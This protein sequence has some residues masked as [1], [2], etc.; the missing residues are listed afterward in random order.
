MAPAKKMDEIAVEVR[1][2]VQRDLETMKG[3]LQEAFREDLKKIP[4]LEKSLEMVIGK[5][6]ELLRQREASTPGSTASGK[7]LPSNPTMTPG[8]LNGRNGGPFDTAGRQEAYDGGGFGGPSYVRILVESHIAKLAFGDE[9]YPRVITIGIRVCSSSDPRCGR[10]DLE[11]GDLERPEWAIQSGPPWTSVS[12]AWGYVRILVESHIAKMFTSVQNG[13]QSQPN[14]DCQRHCILISASNPHPLST[15]VFRPQVQNLEQSENIDGQTENRLSDTET[16]AKSFAQC[17]VSLSVISPKQLPKLRAIYNVGKRNPR[18]NDP[19]I[20]NAKNPYFL[21]LLSEN[22]LEARAALRVPSLPSNQSPVKMDMASVPSVTGPPPTSMPSVNGSVMNRQPISVGNMPPATVKVN[23][24][25]LINK[26]SGA[27]YCKFHGFWTHF[28]T[29]SLCCSCC[30]P[31]SPVA[32]FFTIF[33]S[34]DMISNN[35]NGP[36]LKPIVSSISQPLRPVGPAPANVNILNNLLAKHQVINSAALP[37]GQTP[38]GMHMSNMISN[39]M[40][41]STPAQNILPSGQPA[42]TSLPGSGPLT[43]VTQTPG[44]STFSAAT[45]NVSGNSN[46]GVSQPMNN[47]QGGVSM[48]QSV[49]TMSQGNISGAQMVQTGMGMNQNMISGLG[50]SVVSSGTGTMM[51]T[52]GMSQQVQSG[53]QPLGVNNNSA[54]SIPMSQQASTAPQA[55]KYVKVWEGNLSGQRQGQPVFITRLEGYRNATASETLAANWPATMQIVRLI[56]QDHMN[57]KQYVGKAD[58]LVFRAMNQHGFLGQLQEKKLCAVI[59]LPSQTLLLSVSDKACRLIGMLF[60][61]SLSFGSRALDLGMTRRTDGH[62]KEKTEGP[63]EEFQKELEGIREDLKKIPRLEQGMELLLE[64]MD[65]LMRQR[66]LGN[67]EPPWAAEGTTADPP[68]PREDLHREGG[69]RAELCTRRVEMPVF[70]GENPDGWSIRA[71]RYFAMNKMTEREKL[72][73]A[74]VSLEGEALAWFQ[75]EDGRSPIRSWMVLKLML[76]ERFRPMQEGSLCEKFLSL[77]QETT[78]RDY[79]RQF[80]ILAAP[81]TELSE[82]VLESTFVKGLKP[83]IRA[84][85]RLM[86]PERLGRIMEV[87][88]RVE[89]RNQSVCGPRV[90]GPQGPQIFFLE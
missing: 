10:G 38:I 67:M 1:E 32:D 65:L 33:C 77:R 19:P 85:I 78:V 83:E 86:K 76:L 51:P 54:A 16:I 47:L 34:Q 68:A 7:E 41:S 15:P 37:M 66:D 58:F 9:F 22:F 13:N 5:L 56:S 2:E 62:E 11:R 53:M 30:F 36:D 25:D 60:P 18:A 52:P 4:K 70:D 21:V 74:V 84:E 44:L 17:L 73:V 27:K 39:G 3:E 40:A 45:S 88:Q 35:E 55:S 26:S 59:Q 80:E 79:R 50:Q 82:Q 49:P 75:W 20:D 29:H 63:R 61:G 48:G 69:I 71:E 8:G 6:G 31:R 87:A 90:T 23:G 89:E 43:Q 81:L 28:S 46:I 42:I 12:E 72:D 64:R 57:N 24:F 14:M